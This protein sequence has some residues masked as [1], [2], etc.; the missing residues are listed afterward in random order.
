MG[1]KVV[2]IVRSVQ[3]KRTLKPKKSFLKQL[4]Y[5]RGHGRH[6]SLLTVAP[7]N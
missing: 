6:Y 4:S 2:S 7:P 1:S 5:Y 3:I